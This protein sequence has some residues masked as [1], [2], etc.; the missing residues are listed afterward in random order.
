MSGTM[1]LIIAALVGAG[2]IVG[3]G[4]VYVF[5]IAPPA[6]QNAVLPGGNGN[7]ATNAQL[8]VSMKADCQAAA[9]DGA[10]QLAICKKLLAGRTS[11]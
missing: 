4:A 11:H 9:Q 6:V 2:V 1:K 10:P 3:A 5:V 8:D 7:S